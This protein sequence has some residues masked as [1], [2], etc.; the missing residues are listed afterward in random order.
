MGSVGLGRPFRVLEEQEVGAGRA[1]CRGKSFPVKGN[2]F[3]WLD[4]N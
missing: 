4:V 2:K 3:A 1:E